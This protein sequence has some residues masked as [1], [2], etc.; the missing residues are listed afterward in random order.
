MG[1]ASLSG[2]FVYCTVWGKQ[3]DGSWKIVTDTGSVRTVRTRPRTNVRGVVRRDARDGAGAGEGKASNCRVTAGRNPWDT[4][5]QS[6]WKC[7][8]C[9]GWRDAPDDKSAFQSRVPY[10]CLSRSEGRTSQRSYCGKL[11]ADLRFHGAQLAVIGITGQ[12]CKIVGRNDGAISS[13]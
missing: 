5:A 13:A 3:D 1:G 2:S 9:K 11:T 10:K 4:R 12:L 7:A 8:N 6:L